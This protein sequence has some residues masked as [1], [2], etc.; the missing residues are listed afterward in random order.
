MASGGIFP[1]E[2]AAARTCCLDR[3]CD[4]MTDAATLALP[5]FQ[6]IGKLQRAMHEAERKVLAAHSAGHAAAM[7]QSLDTLRQQCDRFLHGLDEFGRAFVA[8]ETQPRD[9]AE[10]SSAA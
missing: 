6:A 9:G 1:A 10:M 8:N 7:R 2:L 4:S 3:W 5:S